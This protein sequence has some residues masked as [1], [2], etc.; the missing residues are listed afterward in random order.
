MTF[1]ETPLPSRPAGRA[2]IADAVERHQ[3]PVTEQSVTREW[4]YTLDDGRTVTASVRLVPH[5]NPAYVPVVPGDRYTVYKATPATFDHMAYSKY[6]HAMRAVEHFTD[7]MAARS[8][9]TRTR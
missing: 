7:A 2:A 1:S 8:G 5:T 9:W 3:T 4:S 6:A